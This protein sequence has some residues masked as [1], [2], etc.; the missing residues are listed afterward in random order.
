ML[1]TYFLFSLNLIIFAIAKILE[2][3]RGYEKHISSTNHTL[4]SVVTKYVTKYDF[5]TLYRSEKQ[6]K[7]RAFVSLHICKNAYLILF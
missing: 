1:I 3:F 2:T 7:Q 5:A 4:Q 6:N